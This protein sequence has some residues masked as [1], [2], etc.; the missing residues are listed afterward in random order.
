VRLVHIYGR[1]TWKRYSGEW[2][3][4]ILLSILEYLSMLQAMELSTTILQITFRIYIKSRTWNRQLHY[5]SAIKPMLAMNG[6]VF[7]FSITTSIY[8]AIFCLF[9][10]N[11]ILGLF[12]VSW[13]LT[14]WLIPLLVQA[15]LWSIVV[16]KKGRLLN[17]IERS[18]NCFN[19]ICY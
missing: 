13:E 11:M 3:M 7:Y 1:D 8:K 10:R 2:I 15:L 14:A 12:Q 17:S 19:Y 16:L 5:I 9:I 6:N 4:Y 18:V